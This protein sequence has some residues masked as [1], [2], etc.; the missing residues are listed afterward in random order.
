MKRSLV[1]LAALLLL[2]TAC[3]SSVSP[4]PTSGVTQKPTPTVTRTHR[5]RLIIGARIQVFVSILGEPAKVLSANPNKVYYFQPNPSD[6]NQYHYQVIVGKG[7]DGEEHIS[8][9]FFQLWNGEQKQ[10]DCSSI[11]ADHASPAGKTPDGEI[12]ISPD[13]NDIFP[14]GAF[15]DTNLKPVEPG[16]FEVISSLAKGDPTH[17]LGC[18][19]LIGEYI[20]GG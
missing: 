12:F 14:A 13:L 19:V 4:S 8:E 1:L 7:K 3:G 20:L 11:K 15:V 2:L 17:V 18:H 5:A 16:T 10:V 9:F 6:E